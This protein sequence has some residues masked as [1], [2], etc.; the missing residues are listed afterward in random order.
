MSEA[1]KIKIEVEYALLLVQNQLIWKCMCSNSGK[2][3]K[4]TT[5]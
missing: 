5:K 2:L 1:D 3:V 4:V